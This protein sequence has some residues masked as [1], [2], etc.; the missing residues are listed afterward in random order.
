MKW[1]WFNISLVWKWHCETQCEIEEWERLSLHKNS[2][3]SILRIIHVSNKHEIEG[4]RVRLNCLQGG[5]DVSDVLNEQ[6]KMKKSP[7]FAIAYREW[8]QSKC[9]YLQLFS[10]FSIERSMNPLQSCVIG[11][12][13]RH[14]QLL[15][16]TGIEHGI[17]NRQVL[18]CQPL[19]TSR[20]IE[21]LL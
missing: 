5:G 14:T 21:I 8:E 12:D 10:S 20:M 4:K 16:A 2:F 9:I 6:K 19:M 3:Q 15:F 1:L 13:N 18:K 7:H 11:K 17:H